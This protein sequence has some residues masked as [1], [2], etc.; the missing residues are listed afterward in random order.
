MNASADNAD[1]IMKDIKNRLDT[2][3]P[4]AMRTLMASWV[5]RI[6]VIDR[7]T[8]G[9]LATKDGKS[10]LLAERQLIIKHLHEL[11]V[12]WDAMNGDADTVFRKMLNPKT[13]I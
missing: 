13:D 8:D 1:R 9:R 6:G 12:C 2:A 3:P 7:Y 5:S 4:C 11:E 10:Q